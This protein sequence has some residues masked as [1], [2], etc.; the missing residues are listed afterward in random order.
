MSSARSPHE[1]T[2]PAVTALNLPSGALAWP[3]SLAP[4]Q[5]MVPSARSPHE[6]HPP[7]VMDRKRP[8]GRTA[9]PGCAPAGDGAVA[10]QPAG[11]VLACG[12]SLETPNG[13]V[14]LAVG[15]LLP[16]QVM[17]PSLRSPHEC[18]PHRR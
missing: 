11:V 17:V 7:T 18:A 13:C 8:A 6:C 16:Q 2:V 1:W 10:A 12:D 15:K 4:Q 5:V 3:W 14:A 9:H